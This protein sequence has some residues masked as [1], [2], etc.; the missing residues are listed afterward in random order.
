[1]CVAP[2]ALAPTTAPLERNTRTLRPSITWTPTRSPL[3]VAGLNSAT[4][5]IWI[6]RVFSTIP[7]GLLA[8]G[9]AL[10]C[11]LTTLTPSTRTWSAS[12][13]ASTVPRRFLSRPVRTMTS[14]PLRSLFIEGSLQHFWGQR[15]DLHELLGT[16]FARNGSEDAGADRLQL[17]VEQYGGVATEADQRTV[18][19]AHTLGGANHHGVVDF[20]FLD[21]AAGGCIFDAHLDDVADTGIT[22]L[23]ATEHLDAHDS[24]R[25]GVVGHVQRGLHLDHDFSCSNLTGNMVFHPGNPAFPASFGPVRSAARF[26][27]NLHRQCRDPGLQSC[28]CSARHRYWP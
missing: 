26:K 28:G 21:A 5:E 6:G 10:T 18:F 17:G 8:M 2:Y 1:M 20:A 13:R 12:T 24:A 14:S 9:L 22:A 23:G 11:F 7:P 19:A 25:T 4:L 27:D 16:Q 3:P 15:H